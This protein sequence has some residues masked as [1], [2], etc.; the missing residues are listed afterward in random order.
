MGNY[1]IS[2]QGF[3]ILGAAS[4]LMIVDGK[5]HKNN[6]IETFKNL[7]KTL[8]KDSSVGASIAYLKR[9]TKDA[10]VTAKAGTKKYIV[11]VFLKSKEDTF[12][13]ENEQLF[14]ND[15]PHFHHVPS[16]FK[17]LPVYLD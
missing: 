12:K 13:H 9:R 11:F 14:I 7:A 10:W 5:I 1:A 6:R 8:H 17:V 15:V 16:T 2:Y 4:V 3:A